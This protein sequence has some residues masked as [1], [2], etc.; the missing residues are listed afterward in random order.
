[1]L[2]DYWK[3]YSYGRKE[4]FSSEVYNVFTTDKD[5]SDLVNIH[6]FDLE[7]CLKIGSIPTKS[8]TVEEDFHQTQSLQEHRRNSQEKD[9]N[10]AKS[11]FENVGWM[12]TSMEKK[13]NMMTG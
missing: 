1:M 10:I 3:I 5:L 13:E 6:N 11:N 2:N 7:L 8:E 9:Y 12:E 4:Y